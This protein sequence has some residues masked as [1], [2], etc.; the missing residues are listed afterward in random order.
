VGIALSSVFGCLRL[1]LNGTIIICRLAICNL[2]SGLIDCIC[3]AFA[4]DFRVTFNCNKTKSITLGTS[5]ISKDLLQCLYMMGK[6]L[7][8]LINGR[9]RS[10]TLC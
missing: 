1:S 3:E 9:I 10:L 4:N 7:R 5:V 8:M 2:V 6:E